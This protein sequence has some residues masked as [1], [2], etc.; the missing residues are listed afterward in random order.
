VRPCTGWSNGSSRFSLELRIASSK[1]AQLEASLPALATRYLA[2][3]LAF[4]ALLALSVLLAPDSLSETALSSALPFAT[5]LALAAVAQSLVMR[6]GGI[7]LSVPAAMAVVAVGLMRAADATGLGPAAGV[8]LS[9]VLGMLPAVVAGVLVAYLELSALIVTMALG[10]LTLG[11]TLWYQT[12]HGLASEVPPALSTW[13]ANSTLGLPSTVLAGLA[14]LALTALLLYATPAGRRLTAVGANPEAARLAGLGPRGYVV[15]AY[16]AAGLLVA[17][18]ALL[19][20]S[21]VKNPTLRIGEPYLLAPIAAVVLG[22][23]SLSGGASSVWATVG[24]ALFL[25]QVEQLL[26]ARGFS[27][28]AKDV[29]SGL[30]LALGMMLAGWSGDTPLSRA[31]RHLRRKET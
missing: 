20:A 22:G 13:A 31:L 17:L 26:R 6:V 14:I 8:A 5:F 11:A 23:A 27:S 7:D 10:A 15:L 30:A 29:L 9:L 16:G 4:A 19:L 24:A 18:D 28:A 2:I 21:F 12:T 1:S 3:W 25:A